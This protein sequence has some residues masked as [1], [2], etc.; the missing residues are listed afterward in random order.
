MTGSSR[1]GNSPRVSRS[2]SRKRRPTGI[3]RRKQRHLTVES[4]EDRRMMAG[5]SS[6]VYIGG[7]PHEMVSY[8]SA[9]PEGAAA[10]ALQEYNR[11]AQ[12]AGQDTSPRVTRAIPN[13]PLLDQQWHLINI[14]QQVGQPDFQDIFG[15]AGQDINVASVWEGLGLSNINGYTGEGVQ[16]A[17]VDSGVEW[18]HEDLFANIDPQLQFD[19]LDNDFNASPFIAPPADPDNI[20]DVFA[21]AANA[22]GTAVAGIIGAVG[23]NGIGV[24]GVAYDAQIVPIRLIDTGQTPQA[25]V[26][27]FRFET[28]IIDITNNSWGPSDDIRSWDGPTANEVFAFRDSIFFGRDGK[29]IIH[30][31]AAG[32]GADGAALDFSGYD[33]YVNS[34]YTIGVTGVDHDGHYNNVDGTVTGYPEISPAVLVA[35]PTGSV[36]LS[37]GNELLV[38]SGITTTDTTGDTGFNIEPDPV[39][40]QEFDRD[41]LS[42][43]KYAGRFNGTSASAP[44]VAGVVGLMLEANP[45]LNWRDVQEILLR[46]ARQNAPTE[47]MADGEDL[48]IGEEYQSTWITNQVPLFHDPD[49]F[50]PLIPNSLQIVNPTLDPNLGLGGNAIH[51]APTPQVLTNGAGYTVSQG[52]GTNQEATGFAHG[53]VDAQLAVQMAEQWHIKQ[54]ALPDELSFT[55]AIGV[56]RANPLPG[57][58]VV[59]NVVGTSDLIIPGGYGGQGGFSSYW[60][61]YF[62]PAPNFNQPFPTRGTPIELSVPDFNNMSIETVEVSIS[63]PA[64][65]VA[66]FMDHVRVVLV[67]PDGTH[68]ELNH[69]YVD[70]SFATPGNFHQADSVLNPTL[71]PNGLNA[72]ENPVEDFNNPGSVFN[73]LT[74]FVFSTN[75]SWGERSDDSIIFDPTS[76]EPINDLSGNGGNLFNAVDPSAGTFFTQGWNLYFEN[77]SPVDLAV[78]SFEVIWHGSPIGANTER[79]LGAI[80]L[81]DGVRDG[82]FNYSRVEQQL[83]DIDNDTSTF[84]LG[85]VVNIVDEDQES[86]ASN[87]T[88]NAFRDVNSNGQLD[89]GLDLLVDQFVTGADGNYYFDLT[90]NDYII[91]L[92]T[93]SLGALTPITDNPGSDIM[94]DYQS[95]WVITSDWFTPWD[96]DIVGG[97]LVVPVDPITGAPDPFLDGTGNIIQ[98]GMRDIN[99]LL[100]EPVDSPDAVPFSG[101]VYADIAG[102][103]IF[104]DADVA[105]PNQIVYGDMN[106]NGNLDPGEAFTSTDQNGQYELLVPTEIA[107]LVTVGVVSP[108]NWTFSNPE[109]GSFSTFS[110]PG[111]P[112]I[113]DFYLQPPATTS[114]GNGAPLSGV[115]IGNVFFDANENGFQESSETG[116]QGITV[117]LDLNDNDILDIDEDRAVT[118]VNGAYAFGGLSNGNYLVKLD[119]DPINLI[120]QTFPFSDAPQLASVISGGTATGVR[121]G[122]SGGATFD[123][124]DLPAIYGDITSGVNGARHP[125]GAYYLGQTVDAEV[126][127]VVLAGTAFGDDFNL[128]PDEDGVEL[129]GGGFEKGTLATF[130]ITASL[131]GGYLQAW[132]DLDGDGNF[133]DPGERVAEDLILI[134]GANQ[135]QVFIPA[136]APDKIFARFRYG[137]FGLELTGQAIV[138]EVEDYEFDVL[139]TESPDPDPVVIVNDSDFNN[140]G[141]VNGFDFLRLQRGMGTSPNA[142]NQ[143]G[144]ANQDGT[145]DY[146]DLAYW[147]VE[148]GEQAEVTTP[149]PAPLVQEEPPLPSLAGGALKAASSSPTATHTPV[150]VASTA[151]A[152][153]PVQTETPTEVIASELPTATI[154]QLETPATP[155]GFTQV[156]TGVP[157]FNSDAI[158][159]EANRLFRRSH[160]LE[161][162]SMAHAGVARLES[163]LQEVFGEEVSALGLRAASVADDA[164]EH[165]LGRLDR[166]LEE[167]PTWRGGENDDAEEVLSQALSEFMPW[168]FS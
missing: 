81:D 90:P 95:E 76:G 153:T 113:A 120:E 80:G 140:D 23:D 167:L 123:Y 131:H 144:D 68:S 109:D 21:S 55:T 3:S 1:F 51:Y 121:F 11:Y 6:I 93:E 29:G 97:D 122:V 135:I 5:D 154:P 100:Q 155:V 147:E 16:I 75:R 33:G 137:E 101:F 10:I 159:A 163:H 145:V 114:P 92:D 130:E 18:T 70:T 164:L 74:T 79:V 71:S 166:D 14:G 87:V 85:E 117:Y 162:H 84:R 25:I 35:A 125:V 116:S 83:V 158:D 27:A 132:L 138:G 56:D 151:R 64:A 110:V 78:S 47:T 149:P 19:P 43:E 106:R 126:D 107:T 44:V 40:G 91:T 136:T 150:L 49:V 39:T 46:S 45:E 124:G 148:F 73:G 102:D 52:R 48:A 62:D 54:Q 128:L 103:G 58:E 105:L 146:I 8:S 118:N 69:Y 7:I 24:T 17:V 127:A 53:V 63:V 28:D 142:T 82:E 34:R 134:K 86:F 168:R 41:Y 98:Y 15:V 143:D 161:R 157:S 22:H 57:A 2:K 60:A 32:N 115:I 12:S 36:F 20:A 139:V 160:R 89:E 112:E 108:A 111:I 165:L 13:D 66:E 72:V 156:D 96:H 37:V 59:N 38:G 67:S 65:D 77:Y 9:T 88:V 133:T 94:P 129:I 42:D 4:L 99:F 61:E 30:V 104:N 50:D 152:G 141:M 26:D 119:L 31:W